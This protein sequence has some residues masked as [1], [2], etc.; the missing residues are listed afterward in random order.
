MKKIFGIFAKVAQVAAPIFG[1]PIG[2]IAS[3]VIGGLTNSRSGIPGLLSG[4]T[5]GFSGNFVGGLASGFI[6]SFYVN[7]GA[8]R[9]GIN[10][11][12]GAAIAAVKGVI[13]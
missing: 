12:I 1:G 7:N 8:F 6:F 5:F 11:A 2:S 10:E 9:A 4:V 13:F 3:S